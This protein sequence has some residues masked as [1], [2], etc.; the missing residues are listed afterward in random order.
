MIRSGETDWRRKPLSQDSRMSVTRPCMLANISINMAD[1]RF[2]I[3][4]VSSYNYFLLKGGGVKH[5]PPG[6]DWWI[7]LVGN[8]KYYN[9][10]LSVNGKASYHGDSYGKD[11]LTDVIRRQAVRFLNRLDKAND[12]SPFLM[13]LAPPACH[14]PFTPAPQNENVFSNITAPRTKAFNR[15]DK[16]DPAK[17]WLM[18][19]QPRTMSAETVSMVDSMFRDRW[20]TL[21]SVDTM[22]D[23]VVQAL[24]HYKMLDSTYLIFTSDN[25]YHMGQF[26][27]PLDKRLPY[28]FDIRVSV[29]L[30][31]FSTSHVSISIRFHFGCLDPRSKAV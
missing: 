10:T 14:A 20:R 26:G 27:M 13:M 8:S 29:S 11:Y 30:E 9:Y 31:S 21:R 18:S 6:W 25:G 15:Y 1:L 19:T 12:D 4:F 2:E 7:G 23:K 24:A 16:S 5:V 3:V 17:H 22:V 28:E